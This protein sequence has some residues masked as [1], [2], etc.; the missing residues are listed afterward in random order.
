MVEN[1]G[2]LNEEL[3]LAKRWD[4]WKRLDEMAR[5]AEQGVH[6]LSGTEIVEFVRLH[7]QTS[8]DLAFMISQS[9]N[10]DVVQ[11][12]NSL[13]S[14]SYSVLYRRSPRRA[15]EV[16]KDALVISAKTCRR[17]FRPIFLAAAVFFAGSFF[18]AGSMS[19]LP[20]TRDYFIPPAAE[21]LFEQ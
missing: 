1:R 10:Q 2:V 8:G 19:V 6:R 11:Y 21:E 12:L 13:V 20:D 14:R 3:F 16:L 18:A 4:S 9:S 7:R 17:R 5:R 15:L